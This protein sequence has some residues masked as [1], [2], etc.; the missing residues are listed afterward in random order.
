M[1]ILEVVSSRVHS[2]AAA[3]ALALARA[4]AGRGHEVTFACL[5]GGGLERAAGEADLALD[6]SLALPRGAEVWAY[7]SDAR[8]LR[9]L[10]AGRG[11]EIVHVHRSSEHTSAFLAFR[12]TRPA[13]LVRTWHRSEPPAG[14]ARWLLGRADAVVT[15]SAP[16]HAALGGLGPRA[17]LV[18]GGVGLEV[19]R[20]DVSSD[21]VRERHGLAG[22]IVVGT[23]SRLKR[24]R[25]LESFLGAAAALAPVRPDLAFAVVGAGELAEALRARARGLGIT[26]RLVF[27]DD[28]NES[29]VERAACIDIGVQLAAGSDASARAGMELAA[30][31]RPVIALE[32]G[33][34]AGLVEHGVTGCLVKAPHF[35]S[36]AQCISP[37]VEDPAK[38]AAMGAAA[39][40]RAEELFDIRRV[41][42]EHEALFEELRDRAAGARGAP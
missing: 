26:G 12:R 37:L 34:L 19:F 24:G 4:L 29:F 40:A 28:P 42:A 7:L 13:P 16:V 18:R 17:C 6:L 33:A 3:P 38:R 41:A 5:P 11:L 10:V 23:I 1:R 14:F 8:R 21:A 22:K 32:R 15:P 27:L 30:L 25:R 20:P 39:R 9:V 31:G 35:S 36:I 2:G